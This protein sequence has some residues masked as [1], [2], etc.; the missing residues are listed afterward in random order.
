MNTAEYNAADSIEPSSGDIQKLSAIRLEL[1]KDLRANLKCYHDLLGRLYRT[2][3]LD[4][5]LIVVM[6]RETGVMTE[7]ET[8]AGQV[9]SPEDVAEM[10][11]SET[12]L[13][14]RVAVSHLNLEHWKPKKR[15]TKQ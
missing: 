15:P 2:D 4:I 3:W 6:L 5:D 8:V 13:V 14:R 7:T 11:L 12:Q 1:D 9:I 10:L